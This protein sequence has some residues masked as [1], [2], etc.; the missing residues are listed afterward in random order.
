MRKFKN[1]YVEITKA[2]N[3]KCTFCPSKNNI[4]KEYLS[5]DNFKHVIN[6]IKDY[7]E[8]IYL[9]ILGEPLLHK[10]LFK[11]I[12]YA[13]KYV[14]VSLTTNGHL[15]KKY[16]LELC[17]SNLHILNIS[18]QSIDNLN[19]LDEYFE[20][21]NNLIVNRTHKLPIHLRI[22][23]DKESEKVKVLNNR[24][25]ELINNY[26]LLEYPYVTLSVEDEFDW[27]SLSDEVNQVRTSCLGGKSQMGILVNG[28]VTICCLDYL[29]YTKLG[30]IYEDS[31]ENIKNSKLFN[32][33][34]KGWNDLKPYFEL[35]KKCT[36]RNR[37]KK[38]KKDEG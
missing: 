13:S 31:F 5:F 22:W 20:S 30:N 4:S 6:Q 1:V 2:C 36:Y 3:L 38:E 10:D 23:N 8:G 21:L 9:H 12:E 28:D 24:L 37:F 16:Y 29:G 26:R 18:L 35:C 7:T 14:K 34:I 15:I 17:S 19:D 27:P 11:F 33:V 25:N 32:D